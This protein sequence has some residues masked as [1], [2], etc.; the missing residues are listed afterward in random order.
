[1]YRRIHRFFSLLSCKLV[2]L[3]GESSDKTKFLK[4]HNWTLCLY[5]DSIRSNAELNCR[6]VD[7]VFVHQFSFFWVTAILSISYGHGGNL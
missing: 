1:M 7:E 5:H 3:P 2:S 4:I 6:I